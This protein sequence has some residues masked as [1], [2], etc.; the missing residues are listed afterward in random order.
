MQSSA[1]DG[2]RYL[3]NRF[4]INREELEDYELREKSGDLWL[5]SSDAETGLE[6]ETHGIRFIRIM[7]IGMKPTT[8]ALQ[9]L[10]D[11]IGKNTVELDRDEL[12]MLLRREDMVERQMSE[13]GYV[14]LKFQDHIIGCGFYRNGTVSSRV[15]KGRGKELA[16]ILA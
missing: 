10:G 7:D 1:S 6:V 15:P 14:A 5:V 16:K 11:D 3:E 4:G 2:W 13:E 12:V 8:Y 9:L